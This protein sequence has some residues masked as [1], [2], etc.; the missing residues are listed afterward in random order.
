MR[1][2]VLI[3]SQFVFSGFV[4]ILWITSIWSDPAATDP[5]DTDSGGQWRAGESNPLS[6]QY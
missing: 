6:S 5:V 2:G 1:K 4:V 3:G